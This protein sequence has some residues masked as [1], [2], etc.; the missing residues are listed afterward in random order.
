MIPAASLRF[1][2]L[3]V[4][5]FSNDYA[6]LLDECIASRGFSTCESRQEIR[7][8]LKSD[9]PCRNKQVSRRLRQLATYL[10]GNLV[11]A[12]KL[13]RGGKREKRKEKY[14]I[15]ARPS[16]GVLSHRSASL[17]LDAPSPT[18]ASLSPRCFRIQRY[19]VP[20]RFTVFTRFSFL[21]FSDFLLRFFAFFSDLVVKFFFFFFRFAT[22]SSLIYGVLRFVEILNLTYL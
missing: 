1:R 3:R 22:V 20:H 15:T 11:V 5:P 12:A 14:S 13:E 9:K 7:L 4:Q 2:S 16:G 6:E 17:I 18:T 8:I 21:D 10:R 19:P